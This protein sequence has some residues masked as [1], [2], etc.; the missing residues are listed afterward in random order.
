MKYLKL[1]RFQNLAMLALMQILFRYTFM[2]SAT[3]TELTP[4][5][6]FLALSHAQ[7]FL[8]VLA[9]VCIAAAGYV[10]ND[11]MDQ[12]TDEIAKK[13]VVGKTISEKAAYNLYVILN[14]T[15]VGIG[16]YLSNAIDKPSFASLFIFT[17]ALLYFYATTLKQI[18]VLGN[19]VVAAI[20]SFSILI[21]GLFDLVPSTH[22]GNAFW[23][24]NK[25][26]MRQVFGILTDYAIF[27]FIINFLRELVKDVEDTD[28]DY[29]AG[30]PTLPVLIGKN[31][32]M[33]IVFGLSFIPVL[34]FIYYVNANLAQYS[35]VLFYALLFIIA[36]LLI[37]TI[38]SWSAKSNKEFKNLSFL[39]KAVLF[40]GILS[41]AVI[42]YATTHHA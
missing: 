20:L 23:Q 41:I 25:A 9:T 32:T 4:T 17:A 24:G 19:I 27:A 7:F 40:F 26:Q 22:E 33:K 39:L 42:T 1:V 12:E 18:A 11:I 30:I 34:L 31:R 14:V 8:L 29:A 3:Y 2:K 15:G 6:N 38:K 5:Y 13:R 10:I 37:F 36:P 28:A 35:Y 21:L 16:F